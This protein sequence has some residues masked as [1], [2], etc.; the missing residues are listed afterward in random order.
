MRKLLIAAAVA[1]VF[2]PGQA[3]HACNAESGEYA[4]GSSVSTSVEGTP[5]EGSYL[6]GDGDTSGGG[7]GFY[8]GDSGNFIEVSVDGDGAEVDGQLVRDEGSISGHANSD[9]DVELCVNGDEVGA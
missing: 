9:G 8:N 2:I 1:A 5:L 4:D 7:G 3:A 6:A